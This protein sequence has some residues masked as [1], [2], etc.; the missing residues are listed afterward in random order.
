MLY[1]V[2]KCTRGPKCS[3]RS[4]NHDTSLSEYF[5]LP[6]YF[7]NINHKYVFDNKKYIDIHKSLLGEKVSDKIKH[8]MILKDILYHV[9]SVCIELR[10]LLT[11]VLFHI[12]TT[13]VYTEYRK[14]YPG[15]GMASKKKCED[16]C[17]EL[18]FPEF[19]EYML[20]NFLSKM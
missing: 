6:E 17:H 10:T 13:D 4:H 8:T 18:D 15:F 3:I 14:T 7:T 9:E 11:V 2:S 1:S 12:I 20:K 16:F 19:A 5:N